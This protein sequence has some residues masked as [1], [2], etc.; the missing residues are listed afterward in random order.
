MIPGASQPPR[1]LSLSGRL[2]SGSRRG[3]VIRGSRWPRFE[4]RSLIGFLF[5]CVRPTR[6]SSQGSL[7]NLG[8][9]KL[10]GT[11]ARTSRTSTS[12][13]GCC[14]LRTAAAWSAIS[15]VSY[16]HGFASIATS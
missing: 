14:F 15:F 16:V 9:H 5:G 3:L 7:R 6:P 10:G 11:L 4:W 1:C 2:V 12:L 13:F 8:A